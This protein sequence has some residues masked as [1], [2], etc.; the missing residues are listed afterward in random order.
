MLLSQCKHSVTKH[1]F[2]YMHYKHL[3]VSLCF[4]I[5]S[6]NTE[7]ALSPDAILEFS[8]SASLFEIGG[9]QTNIISTHGIKL[10]VIQPV[11]SG[12]YHPGPPTG[13]EVTSIDQTWQFVS[14]PPLMRTSPFGSG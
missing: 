14:I 3:L 6:S 12:A 4:L 13:S 8:G 7:A 11:D 9:V 10:N 5:T 1:I 2:S